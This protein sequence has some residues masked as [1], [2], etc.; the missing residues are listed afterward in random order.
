MLVTMLDALSSSMR[1]ALDQIR[2]DGA[3]TAVKGTVQALMSRGL[4][5]KSADKPS[6]WA[7]SPVGETAYFEH[8]VMRK[9]QASDFQIGQAVQRLVWL[10]G[11]YPWRF[12]WRAG[13]VLRLTKAFVFVIYPDDSVQRHVPRSLRHQPAEGTPG[14]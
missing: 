8:E 7:L 12:K 11:G 5:A 6:A 9:Q 1:A 4:I 3:T 13:R 10:P 14:Q 2:A